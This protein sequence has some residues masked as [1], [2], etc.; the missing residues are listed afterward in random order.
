MKKFL[1]EVFQD[2]DGY[3]SFKRTALGV[4]V[5]LLAVVVFCPIFGI[6]YP[7]TVVPAL[8]DLIKV[9]LGFVVA[10][11]ITKFAKGKGDK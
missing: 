7:D 1:K 8:S 2:V 10:E 6:A 9:G 11:H 3:Y 5:F 4:V